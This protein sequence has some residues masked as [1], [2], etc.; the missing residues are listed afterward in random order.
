MS[1]AGRKNQDVRMKDLPEAFQ[2]VAE[3]TGLPGALKMI[4]KYKGTRLFIPKKFSAQH[5]LAELLGIEQARRLGKRFGGE[6][7]MI[8][9]AKKAFRTIRN[10]KIVRRYDEGVPVRRLAV[11]YDLTE[12]SIYVILSDPKNTP[13]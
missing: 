12:R 5:A 11:E 2:E 9:Q 1:V 7:L 6:V 8:P 3:V 4:K 13:S 10:R